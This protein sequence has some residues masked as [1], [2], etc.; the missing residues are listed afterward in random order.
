[1]WYF[2]VGGFELTFFYIFLSMDEEALF[3]EFSIWV[4]LWGGNQ[5]ESN[6]RKCVLKVYQCVLK[7][8]G[9]SCIMWSVLLW[10][11]CQMRFWDWQW[12][13]ERGVILDHSLMDGWPMLIDIIHASIIIWNVPDD[14]LIDWALWIRPDAFIRQDVCVFFFLSSS[15]EPFQCIR[16]II[17][18]S[19]HVD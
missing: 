5:D 6:G 14:W 8:N 19:S 17:D 18:L 9:A 3:L 12:R 15:W 4:F 7:A 10:L 16:N 13:Q 11:F 2:H 1:M